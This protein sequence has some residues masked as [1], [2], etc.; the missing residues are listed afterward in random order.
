MVNRTRPARE[1][2]QHWDEDK[3]AMAVRIEPNEEYLLI[4]FKTVALLL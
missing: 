3:L 1:K 4:A 2:M